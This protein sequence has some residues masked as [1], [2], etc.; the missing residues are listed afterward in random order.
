ML[1]DSK[2][3]NKKA[4]ELILLLIPLLLGIAAYVCLFAIGSY[5]S[6]YP[7]SVYIYLINGTH[8]ANGDFEIGHYDN[9][10]TTVHLL[11][12]IIIYVAHAILGTQT[13]FQDVLANP[14]LYIKICSGVLIVTGVL[15]IYFSSRSIYKTFTNLYLALAFQLI[16]LCAYFCT[17]YFLLTRIV[18]ETLILFV[19]IYYAAFVLKICNK[20][21]NNEKLSVGNILTFS[22]ITGFLVVTKITCLPFFIL[23]LFLISSI[24]N[25][26][27]FIAETLLFILLLTFPIW[28][29]LSDAVTWFTNLTTHTGNYGQGE[30]KIINTSLF[31]DNLKKLLQRDLFYYTSLLVLLTI[32]IWGFA[33][34]QWSNYYFKLVFA[35]VLIMLSQVIFA[36]KHFGYHYLIASQSLTIPLLIASILLIKKEYE[37][38]YIPIALLALVLIFQYEK[39]DEQFSIFSEPN[40]IYQTS[41]EVE[42]YKDTPKIITTGYQGSCFVASA[43]NF[44]AFYHG[45]YFFTNYYYLRTLYPTSYFYSIGENKIRHWEIEISN[46]ELIKNNPNI[47]VYFRE[48]DDVVLLKKITEGCDSL[49]KKI[50]RVKENKN[51][52]ETF[53]L[54]ET[55]YRANT[56][57][58]KTTKTV[59]CDFEHINKTAN[60][61]FSSDSAFQFKGLDKITN[62]LYTSGNTS[63][64]T[65]P[66][67]SIACETSIPV[68]KGDR[69]KISV[70][71]FSQDMPGLL[72]LQE[73]DKRKFNFRSE[74]VT[75]I[76]ENGWRTISLEAIIPENY[77][78]SKIEFNL[79]YYG[80]T[81]CYFD[82]LKIEIQSQ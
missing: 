75:T 40:A 34:K 41:L 46:K 38:K 21:N 22:A 5:Y 54:I 80:T 72:L 18:P 44:G 4:E 2:G 7:D 67:N 15:V 37:N 28:H 14:E 65:T 8:I 69:I 24:K 52:R 1:L 62:V 73:V 68:K 51:T 32:L 45:N 81:E 55:I 58:Y 43:L 42:K 60:T 31:Y 16:P 19:V 35:G 10:G 57:V 47:L 53:Y 26:L 49:I 70:N 61:F 33:K 36:A 78:S 56:A 30:E 48:M 76:L 17:H 12:G 39:F 9:P 11:A 82:D 71:S 74:Y 25:K 79:Y 77:T 13:V 59:L 20:L 63:I 64:K 6:T 66:E 50:T 3:T 27:I 23:P 29:K